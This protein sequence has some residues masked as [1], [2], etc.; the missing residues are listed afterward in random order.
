MLA[1]SSTWIRESLVF[2]RFYFHFL[3]LSARNF[4]L[5][6]EKVGIALGNQ[7]WDFP[8]VLITRDW[9]FFLGGGVG[10]SIWGFCLY[11]LGLFIIIIIWDKRS[12]SNLIKVYMCIKLTFRGLNPVI[13]P[14]TH[15]KLILVVWPSYQGCTM[16]FVFF[17]NYKKSGFRRRFF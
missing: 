6:G 16:I 4:R 17:L 15:Q 7:F 3:F 11:D 2:K 5:Q 9:D 13:Y 14:L 10:W 12:Y 8:W 1:T